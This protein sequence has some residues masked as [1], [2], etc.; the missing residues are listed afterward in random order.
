MLYERRQGR[1]KLLL[2]RGVSVHYGGVQVLFDVDLEV[3]EGEIVALLGTNGAGKSTLLKAISG[4]V[5]PTEGAIVFDGRDMTYTPPDETAGRGVTMV[6][7]GQGVFPSLT[8]ARE[9]PARGVA[10]PQGQGP[11]PRRPTERVLEIFPV[12][13]ERLDEPAATSPA[14]SSRC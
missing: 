13:R 11:R 8:V 14:A 6:P 7:G 10:A 5:E 2:V 3:D 12:L 1:A 4:L 9:P